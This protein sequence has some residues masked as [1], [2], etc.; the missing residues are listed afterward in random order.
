MVMNET[1]IVPTQAETYALYNVADVDAGVNLENGQ[2]ELGYLI[3][4]KEV[5]YANGTH[6]TWA[7]YNLTA[8]NE[9]SGRN[10]QGW[11]CTLNSW[12]EEIATGNSGYARSCAGS[13]TTSNCVRWKRG[14]ATKAYALSG[15]GNEATFTS[16]CRETIAPTNKILYGTLDTKDAYYTGDAYAYAGRSVAYVWK[17]KVV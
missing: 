11:G 3:V 1:I 10:L 7:T 4:T 2:R 16:W 6:V 15:I 9:G 17:L 5:D 14:M 12:C 8:H 13:T